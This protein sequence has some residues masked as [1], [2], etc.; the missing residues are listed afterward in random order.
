MHSIEEKCKAVL[1]WAVDHHD[2][3]PSFVESVYYYYEKFDTVTERQEAAVDSII[4]KFLI[5]V[6]SYL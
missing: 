1:D 4:A 6:D 3:D 2:F 5:D